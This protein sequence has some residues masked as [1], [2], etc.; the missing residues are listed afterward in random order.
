MIFLLVKTPQDLW[1][2]ILI[3]IG[4]ELFGQAIMF[5]QLREYI[6]FRRIFYIPHQLFIQEEADHG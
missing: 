2:Y 3:N 4:S 1:K 5:L 6:S